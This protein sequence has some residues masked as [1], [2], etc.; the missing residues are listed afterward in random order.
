MEAQLS[1]K[2]GMTANLDIFVRPKPL[3]KKPEEPD[4]LEGVWKFLRR[5]S[6]LFVNTGYNV[7]ANRLIGAGTYSSTTFNY[8]AWGDGTTA[9]ALTRTAA[10]FYSDCAN[11]DTK[12]VTSIDA[13]D[14]PSLTLRFNCFLSSTDNAVVT[15]KKFALMNADP[16]T[17]MFNEMLFSSPLSKDSYQEYYFRYNLTFSQ[18]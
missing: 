8:F 14:V 2:M 17:V 15:I 3:N 9:P 6:N 11:D 5:E 13:F 4:Y 18:V 7:V 1:E 12:A 16:G 10:D